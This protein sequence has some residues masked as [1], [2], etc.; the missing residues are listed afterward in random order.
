LQIKWNCSTIP[1]AEEGDSKKMH[2]ARLLVALPLVLVAHLKPVQAAPDRPVVLIPGILGTKLCD[3]GGRVVWGNRWSLGNFQELMLPARYDPAALGHQTCGLIEGVNI[4][5]PWQIHQYDDL[6]QT[7]SDLGYRKDVNLY[8]FEYDWRLS[9][10]DTARKLQ[11]FISEK[12]PSGKLDLVAHSM[13]GLIAKLWMVEQGGT[14]RVGTLVTLGTPHTGAASTFKTMDKGWGFWANL[15][16]HGLG[17]V[18]ETAMTFPSF[19]E[20]LP[21][22]GNCCGFRTSGSRQLEDLDPFSG[23]AWS[24]FQ[25]VPQSFDND[26]RRAWL[27]R[28][29]TEAKSVLRTPMPSGPKVVRIV[30]SLI[31]TPW[32]VVFD[33]SNGSVIDYI[34]W[35]GDGTVY[36]KSAADD[37]LG[38]ARPALTSHQRIFAD[39]AS[40]QVLR[41]V[42]VEGPEPTKGVL[43]FIKAKLQTATNSFVG[44]AS[45]SA[46]IDPPVL[47]PGQQGRFIVELAGQQDLALADL[48]NVYAFLDETPALQLPSPMR[49]VMADPSG[50]VK[51]R[52]VFTLNAPSELGS[53]SATVHLQSVANLS[54]T[55]V[56]VPR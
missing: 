28:T 17:I 21:A 44:V 10:R 26:E 12:I 38:D 48:S 32:R 56:V 4:L 27:L 6:L 34:P 40:R 18:R 25:W 29:L 3:S 20:L 11:T 51:V 45:A 31:P 22:Y 37:H 23:S 8:I 39:D 50:N 47:E 24:R 49:E 33:P 13:G 46:E 53:F 14:S 52:L 54:D 2:I 30:N 19:Y 41:W 1:C 9:N 7:L 16:A 15:L 42:L 35:P 43:P 36:E 55:G 5:G